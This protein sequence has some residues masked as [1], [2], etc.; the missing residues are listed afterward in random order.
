MPIIVVPPTGSLFS[1]QNVKRFLEEGQYEDLQAVKVSSNAKDGILVERPRSKAMLEGAPAKYRVVDNVTAL[2]PDD[3]KRVAAVFVMGPQWQFQA[4][5]EA[6]RS[7][8]YLFSHV[9]GFHF[10]WSTDK[11]HA[12]VGNWNVISL[13]IPKEVKNR[14]LTA[15]SHL[16]FWQ[17]LERFVLIQRSK[18]APY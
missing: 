7:P 13:T 18:G 5:P 14:H 6:F 10:H 12:N 3:W 15:Q 4:F 9:C 2:R 17:T 16:D 1:L 8:V 11:P